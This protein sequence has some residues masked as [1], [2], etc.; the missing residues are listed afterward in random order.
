[1][2]ARLWD[3]VL[4]KE[5]V[6]YHGFLV[7]VGS[8]VDMWSGVRDQTEKRQIAIVGIGNIYIYILIRM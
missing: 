6:G 2:C 3:D 1:M 8:C 5:H 4:S 7:V